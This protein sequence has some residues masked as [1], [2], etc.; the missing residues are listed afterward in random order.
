[1]SNKEEQKKEE[2]I[3]LRI[4]ASGIT[5][6]SD[7]QFQLF[8]PD[9][10]GSIVNAYYRSIFK[11][12]YGCNIC[13]NVHN[14]QFGTDMVSVKL[15]FIP[16]SDNKVGE[17]VA[18]KDVGSDSATGNLG[19]RMAAMM[20]NN[21]I[22][23]A[24]MSFTPTMDLVDVIYPLLDNF[25][26]TKIKDTPESFIKSGIMTESVINVNNF[27]NK[28]ISHVYLECTSIDKLISSLTSDDKNHVYRVVPNYIS[29]VF[30]PNRV[31]ELYEVQR[32]D[33]NALKK[34]MEQLGLVRRY[35]GL[36]IIT[37]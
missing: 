36:N 25:M 5:I 31:H 33:T 22:R 11:D 27:T 4:E 24:A 14:Y 12:Y 28:Q 34:K 1:M 3:P 13:A 21:E 32:L 18:L 6:N 35:D 10:L 26:C 8:T 16:G 15:C 30:D 19:P 2:R 7:Y 17:Y 20:R 37:N 23:K 29:D 9:E